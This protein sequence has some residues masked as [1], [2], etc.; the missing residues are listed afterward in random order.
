MLRKVG[1][2]FSRSVF[3]ELRHLADYRNYGGAP[4]LGVAGV[5]IISHGSSDE[6]AVSQAIQQGR[7]HVEVGLNDA[8]ARIVSEHAELFKGK[9]HGNGAKHDAESAFSA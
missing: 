8:I 6:L 3:D 4:L 2:L 9:A 5:V 1:Y 7:H